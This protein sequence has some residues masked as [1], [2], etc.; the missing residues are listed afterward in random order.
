MVMVSPVGC[1]TLRQAS[2]YDDDDNEV[3]EDE[4]DDEDDEDDDDDD[5]SSPVSDIQGSI[6]RTSYGH[7]SSKLDEISQILK[8]EERGFLS[9]QSLCIPNINYKSFSRH[10]S[11]KSPK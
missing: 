9:S 1:P 3:D 11:P 8:L 10:F 5:L 7:I 4:G 2:D 6:S